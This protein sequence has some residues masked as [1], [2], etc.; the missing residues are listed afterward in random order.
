[1]PFAVA[2]LGVSRAAMGTR[3]C[4]G[5]QPERRSAAAAAAASV[6][7]VEATRLIGAS[8]QRGSSY[9]LPLV[10]TV[11]E[12]ADR[13]REVER[14]VPLHPGPVVV[15]DHESRTVGAARLDQRA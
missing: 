4:G 5:T 11:G 14:L 6:S 9:A 2:G 1:M 3:L 7:A 15:V 10:E 12:E 13:A 8:R